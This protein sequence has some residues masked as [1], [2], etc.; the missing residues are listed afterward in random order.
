[1]SES[2]YTYR[3]PS[4]HDFTYLLQETLKVYEPSLAALMRDKACSLDGNGGYSRKRWNAMY[5]ILDVSVPV[6]ELGNFT[7][8]VRQQLQAAANSVISPSA[9]YDIMEVRVTPSTAIP[10]VGHNFDTTTPDW[11]R[12]QDQVTRLRR[13]TDDPALQIGTSKDLVETI[14]KSI[15]RE[16][17]PQF[18]ARRSNFYPLV[19]ATLK[20][21]PLVPDPS[22][23]GC[24][25]IKNVITSLAS[26]V[27]NL[28]EIRNLHGTGHGQVGDAA[29]LNSVHGKLAVNAATTIA[30]FLLDSYLNEKNKGTQSSWP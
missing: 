12:L 28:G 18:D 14:C 29:S 5:T 24:E 7:P 20:S 2:Q 21:L 19:R 26:V 3:L 10:P 13:S 16:T 9:G 27:Q 25:N 11:P 22:V 1:M 4:N 6:Q 30:S 8:T 17:D 23:K 15:L